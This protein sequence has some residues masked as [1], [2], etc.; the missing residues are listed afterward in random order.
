M[1]FILGSSHHIPHHTLYIC[2]PPFKPFDILGLPV[3]SKWKKKV[4]KMY[5]YA[6]DTKMGYYD[7]Q[8]KRVKEDRQKL[9]LGFISHDFS[10]HPT[11]FLVEGVFAAHNSNSIVEIAAYSYGEDD[12]SQTRK[13]IVE[14]LGDSKYGGNFFDVFDMSHEDALRTICD[15]SPHILFD[16]QG[17]TLGTRPELMANRCAEIQVNFLAFPG[18]SGAKYID[19]V[20]V[21]RHVA[22]IERAA[23]E[24]TEKLA[25]LPRCYQANYFVNPVRIPTRGSAEWKQLRAAENLSTSTSVF[26]FANLNKQDKID[27]YSFS[28]WMKCLTQV[29]ESLL[30]LLEPSQT[31]A[32]DIVKKNLLSTA[33]KAGISSSRIIFAKRVD[34][35]QHIRR[36]AAGDLFLDTF[37]Y[38]A[39]STATDAM[40]G[41]MPLL[42]LAG[43]SFSNRVGSSLLHSINSRKAASLVTYSVEEFIRVA[44][45]IATT[46]KKASYISPNV[47]S[48]GA[49][50]IQPQDSEESELF[51][52]VSYSNDLDH[53]S[54]M[55]WE[56]KIIAAKNMHIVLTK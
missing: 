46:Q 21:D 20:V 49:K 32:A 4:S 50:F 33:E 28:V 1:K 7:Y 10:D 40:R 34:R 44:V 25:L 19:Y 52:W 43:E 8:P 13:N 12:G 23:D 53:L 36:M 54:K 11:T 16:L 42:T 29:S 35:S 37:Y 9:R 56:V 26:V 2:Q 51:D 5:A 22:T 45:D 27:P 41:G 48:F 30:W 14:R 39:H 18:T 3:K 47:Y 31:A 17:F 38:G 55:M 24:F 6:L 15:D